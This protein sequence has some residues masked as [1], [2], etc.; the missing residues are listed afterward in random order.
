MDIFHFGHS[1]FKL[2]GKS[3]ILVTDPYEGEKV[4]L[5]FPK[6][7]ADI[8]TVSHQHADHN[9]V[10]D[11]EGTPLVVSGPGEYEVKGVR[12]IG[13]PSFH[14]DEKG[15]KRGKNILFRIQMDGISY[16]HCGDLGH[17]LSEEDLELL[18]GIDV[19]FIPVGGIYTINPSQAAAIIAKIEPSIVIPMHYASEQNKDKPDSLLP[20]SAFL[21]EMGKEV[22]PV[23][24]LSITKDK[25]PVEQTIVVVE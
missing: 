6:T 24:K 20:V 18:D 9:A 4:G 13:V 17:M 8:V 1:S 19:L 15:A 16:L 12:I 2:K 10:K 14:D 22:I 3:V 25:L 5:K 21:K 7:T 11:I 23:P